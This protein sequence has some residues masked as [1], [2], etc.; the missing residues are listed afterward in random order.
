MK[1]RALRLHPTGLNVPTKPLLPRPKPVTETKWPAKSERPIGQLA[2]V[3]A[4]LYSE[5][6]AKA[7]PSAE[8]SGTRVSRLKAIRA[9]V[10]S[11]RARKQRLD[12]FGDADT[13]WQPSGPGASN[14]RRVRRS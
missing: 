1:P 3:N 10:P 11:R 7:G 13:R 9:R 8:L 2:P 5:L 14:A 12:S 6:P 4:R